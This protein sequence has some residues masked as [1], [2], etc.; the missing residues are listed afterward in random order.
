[1]EMLLIS[2]LSGLLCGTV[3]SAVLI[4]FGGYGGHLLVQRDLRELRATDELLNER[5]TR[6]VK[7]RAALTPSKKP[8]QVDK[9]L[10]TLVVAGKVPPGANP[11]DRQKIL[12]ERR[13][14]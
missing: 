1:M 6:E 7:A 9:D 12:K 10:A 4:L 3:A 13:G 8:E 14:F 5:L 2:I 11:L